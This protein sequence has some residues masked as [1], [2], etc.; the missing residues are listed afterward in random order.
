MVDVQKR[1][2]KADRLPVF[3]IFGERRQPFHQIR[4]IGD[5]QV[6]AVP[7]FAL[8]EKVDAAIEAARQQSRA[9]AQRQ[10][11]R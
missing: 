8:Q 1:V 2:G 3:D 9:E 6:V 10:T 4:H 7:P 11:R 5:G